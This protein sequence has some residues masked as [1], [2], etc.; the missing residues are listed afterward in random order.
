MSTTTLVKT[1]RTLV[2]AGTT[3]AA[4]ATTRGVLDMRTT[5]GG[6]LTFKIANGATGPTLPCEL[7]VLAA[8]NAGSTPAAAAAGADWK[9]LWSFT[10]GAANS[11]VAE[12]YFEV[13]P[14]VMHLQTE[15]TGN[16]GQGVNIEAFLSEISSASTV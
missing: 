4:G 9:T 1:P 12:D 3:N 5:H 7:R 2:A 11:A 10:A 8:H 13:P 6:L 15:F 16:T 14:G